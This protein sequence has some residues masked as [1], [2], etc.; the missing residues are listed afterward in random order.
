MSKLSADERKT[1]LLAVVISVAICA[2]IAAIVVL[3]LQRSTEPERI[4]AQ[5][6]SAPPQPRDVEA[7]REDTRFSIH[8]LEQALKLYAID[9]NAEFPQGNQD[10]LTLLLTPTDK[11]GKAELPYLD[12]LPLD[13]WGEPLYYEW[14]N[15]KASGDASL[16][17][18][19]WSSGPNRTN[20]S[21]T[22]DDITN[23]DW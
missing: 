6:S 16:K 3:A 17:P 14:P 8:G 21:G 18:A 22:G 15:T 2:S 4:T 9:H 12:R 13:A 1:I 20:E 19:I 5:P 11:L 10:A 23:W 7:A